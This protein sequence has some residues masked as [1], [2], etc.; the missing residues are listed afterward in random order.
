MA[1]HKYSSSRGAVLLEVLLAV[2]IL[3]VG[4][5]AVLQAMMAHA[6]AASAAAE[7]VQAVH[8]LDLWMTPKIFAQ[9]GNDVMDEQGPCLDVLEKFQCSMTLAAD[10]LP[11]PHPQVMF[12]K[13]DMNVLWGSGKTTRNFKVTAYLPK[14]SE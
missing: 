1:A 4:L 11:S 12:Q 2:A 8:A 10:I 3:A 13:I 14:V 7:Y 9:G 6:N 5:T